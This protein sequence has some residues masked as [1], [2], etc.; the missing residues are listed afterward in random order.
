MKL[1]T[2]LS[3]ILAFATVS[4]INAQTVVNNDEVNVAIDANTGRGGLAKIRQDLKA[5]GLDFRYRP[6]FAPDRMLKSVSYTISDTATGVVLGEI[7]EQKDLTQQGISSRFHLRKENG[8]F[9]LVCMGE[10]CE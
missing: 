9:K 4:E 5:V 10:N 6:E 7:T 3:L 8:V 2:T 1:L